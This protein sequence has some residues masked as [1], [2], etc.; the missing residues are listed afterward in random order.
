LGKG[1]LGLSKNLF[2][3]YFLR[4]EDSEAGFRVPDP[5]NALRG[6]SYDSSG[7]IEIEDLAITLSLRRHL[8]CSGLTQSDSVTDAAAFE[9]KSVGG[10]LDLVE[11]AL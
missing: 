7:K 5:R 10:L 9:P 4:R 11:I 2:G 6:N 3:G 1:A 8:G